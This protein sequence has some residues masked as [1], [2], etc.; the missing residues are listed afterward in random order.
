MR[1]GS[2]ARMTP[3]EQ[4]GASVRWLE[5]IAGSE[6]AMPKAVA[7]VVVQKATH[8]AAESR[9][10]GGRVDTQRDEWG[11]PGEL[12]EVVQQMSTPSLL[13]LAAEASEERGGSRRPVEPVG[14]PPAPPQGLPRREIT[15]P[16]GTGPST[17]ASTM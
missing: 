13:W 16:V 6:V 1:N 9:L 3:V 15:L 4:Y 11:R 14:K 8:D 5:E 17:Y 2:H 12:V 7:E 10:S